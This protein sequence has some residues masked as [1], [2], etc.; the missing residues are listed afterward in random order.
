MYGPE[1]FAVL[2]PWREKH[3]ANTIQA[4]GHPHNTRWLDRDAIGSR[5]PTPALS[6]TP[7]SEHDSVNRLV[8][9]FEQLMLIYSNEIQFGTDEK[10]SHILL[11][12]PG[13]K[14]VSARQFVI[15]VRPDYTVHLEDR[16]SKYGTYMVRDGKVEK[17][18]LHGDHILASKLGLP[19]LWNEVV[20]VTG[21]LAYTIEFPNHAAGSSEY[22]EKLGSFRERENIGIPFIGALDLHSKPITAEP[23]QA[24]TPHGKGR[25]AYIDVRKL[26]SSS[27]GTVRLVLNT[28]D[29]KYYVKKTISTYPR[30]PQAERK[31]KRDKKT[32]E[33]EKEEK[34]AHDTWFKEFRSRMKLLQTIDHPNILQ[35]VDYG[36]TPNPYYIMPYYKHGT[37]E[38]LH[39]AGLDEEMFPKIFLELLLGLRVFHDLGC[40]HRDLKGDNILVSDDL[41]L[42]FG[43]PDF[44]KSGDDNALTTVCG[45]ALYAAPEI[46]HGKSQSYGVSVDIW[47]LAICILRIFHDLKNPSESLPALLEDQK[48]KAWNS[49]WY[50]AVF[51]KL[52]ELDENDDQ[53]IDIVKTMLKLDPTERSTVNQCLKRGCENGLFRENRFGDIV[54]A[55]ATEV[56]TPANSWFPNFGLGDGEKTPKPQSPLCD[57]ANN[58]SFLCSLRLEEILGNTDDGA[59]LQVTFPSLPDLPNFAL[60]DEVS[61]PEILISFLG[62]TRDNPIPTIESS[63]ENL[64]CGKGER[65]PMDRSLS[66]PEGDSSG[67][68]A[69]RLK[70]SSTNASDWSWT[71]GLEYSSSEGGI[72]LEDQPTRGSKEDLSKLR[73]TKDTFSGDLENSF[74]SRGRGGSTSP[75]VLAC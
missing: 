31:R 13:V 55:E 64:G 1:V 52:D 32:Q 41:T 19:K 50:T 4:F 38:D 42:I 3:W 65:M 5:E 16:F 7:E 11:K 15:S 59:A 39:K 28:M 6:P 12:F 49:K 25:L 46:W 73:I 33:A 57:S 66:T 27:I 36:E 26:A 18:T 23:S 54:L 30:A 21:N 8:L 48:L 9:K 29:G 56:H 43:D 61:A 60:D 17:Q 24:S 72:T 14:A 62:E 69:R 53:I 22:L 20:I 40:A 58:V 35:V 67:R 37:L 63:E 10:V 74:A 2:T 45:T 75:D 71:V 47:S 68:P 34:E 51:E 70:V 44:L